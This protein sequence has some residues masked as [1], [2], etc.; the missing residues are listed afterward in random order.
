MQD[1][2]LQEIE[3]QLPNGF[4]DARLEE[5]S[6]RLTKNEVQFDLQV[7]VGDPDAVMV[8]EREKYRNAK[9]LIKDIYYFEIDTPEGS[10]SFQAR[11][12]RVDGGVADETSS[13]KPRRPMPDGTFA[14]WFYI[15]N[16]N[17]LIH[18]A[19]KRASFNWV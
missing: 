11:P 4:H 16:W 17:S 9:L 12:S 18:F 8:E 15:E 3:N 6:F 13:V 19:A 5:F 10:V 14:Y 7:F 2:N 1:K